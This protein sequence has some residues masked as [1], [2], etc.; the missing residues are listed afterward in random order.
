MN[1]EPLRKRVRQYLDQVRG[2]RP[3]AG[4]RGGGAWQDCAADGAQ[5]VRGLRKRGWLGGCIVALDSGRAVGCFE[6][7]NC[8]SCLGEYM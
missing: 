1:L 5:I 4:L 6:R 7:I 8:G 2:R 3:N